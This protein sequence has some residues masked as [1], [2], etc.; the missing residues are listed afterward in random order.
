MIIDD[1]VNVSKLFDVQSFDVASGWKLQVAVALRT[2]SA[3]LEW[4]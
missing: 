4:L 2:A 3:F 1:Y